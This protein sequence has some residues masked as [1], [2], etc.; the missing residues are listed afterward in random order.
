MVVDFEAFVTMELC[1]PG[2]GWLLNYFQVVKESL[3]RDNPIQGL[4]VGETF[5]VAATTNRLYVWG[6]NHELGSDQ[7]MVMVKPP[8]NS[9]IDRY[10]IT[11]NS[12]E[13][14]YQTTTKAAKEPK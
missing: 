6:M 4:Q 5:S 8:A 3:E 1:Y 9:R 13:I 10:D 11:K 7:N 2:N 12:L 14:T